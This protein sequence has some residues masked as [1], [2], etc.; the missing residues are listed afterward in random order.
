MEGWKEG[1]VGWEGRT[2]GDSGGE[3]EVQ[4]GERRA[5]PGC[6]AG[7][8]SGGGRNLPRQIHDGQTRLCMETEVKASCCQG[9]C[10]AHEDHSFCMSR[11]PLFHSIGTSAGER[12]MLVCRRTYQGPGW[13][14]SFLDPVEWVSGPDSFFW[15]TEGGEAIGVITNDRE[16]HTALHMVEMRSQPHLPL[17]AQ[18][19][20]G[21]AS[22][23]PTHLQKE[24]TSPP[25]S[26]G[27]MLEAGH[28]GGAPLMVPQTC[29]PFLGSLRVQ[30]V[31]IP[32]W[33]LR[34]H[35]SHG[36]HPP[37]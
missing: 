36:H 23:Q 30:P 7:S 34:W 18:N 33:A 4:D 28:V 19:L 2:R 35:L 37:V 26:A 1:G 31:P 9:G 24:R 32:G 12:P 16:R 10:Q 21:K 11:T 6:W 14:F 27:G 5:G 22:R 8:R 20:V 3:G 17:T 25:T 13:T 29:R 15:E